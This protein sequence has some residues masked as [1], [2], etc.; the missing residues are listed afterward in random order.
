MWLVACELYPAYHK[1][2]KHHIQY[3]VRRQKQT[4]PP[5]DDALRAHVKSYQ[6]LQDIP[7]PSHQQPEGQVA[8]REQAGGPYEFRHNEPDKKR[9]K[10]QSRL[11]LDKIQPPNLPRTRAKN[12]TGGNRE[13]RSRNVLKQEPDGKKSRRKRVRVK[14][15][16]HHEYP[17]PWFLFMSRRGR[18]VERQ[19][20]KNHHDGAGEQIQEKPERRPFNQARESDKPGNG[21]E[22][23]RQIRVPPVD[24]FFN[25]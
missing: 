16:E 20:K 23:K 17:P 8:E 11:R 3:R 2:Q 13:Y 6:K 10:R 12:S 22:E 25:Q 5:P 19:N 1:K 24:F 4:L 9:R 18:F 15:P 7:R 14:H 21:R